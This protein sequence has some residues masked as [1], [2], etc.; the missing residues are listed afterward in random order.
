ML[1]HFLDKLLLFI[2]NAIQ[3]SQLHPF[4]LLQLHLT[5]PESVLVEVPE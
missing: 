5:P 4:L 1:H 2:L 3:N